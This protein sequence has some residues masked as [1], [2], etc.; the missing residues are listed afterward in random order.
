MGAEL[1]SSPSGGTLQAPR[2]SGRDWPPCGL[3]TCPRND[4]GDCAAYSPRRAPQLAAASLAIFLRCGSVAGGSRR[5]EAAVPTA[6]AAPWV[7]I[8]ALPTG[9]HASS[10]CTWRPRSSASPSAARRRGCSRW[11]WGAGRPDA[12]VR[13]SRSLVVCCGHPAAVH[14]ALFIV[15]S[16]SAGLEGRLHHLRDVLTRFRDHRALAS[17]RSTR[18]LPARRS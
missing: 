16:A 14:A 4:D 9:R 10:G 6:S 8:G 1:S 3:I 18:G 13:T 2:A 12:R 7:V 5:G 11:H 17:P 15:G